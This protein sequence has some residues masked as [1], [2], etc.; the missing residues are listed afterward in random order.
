M[1]I[2]I[3]PFNATDIDFIESLIPRFSE[4]ELPHWRTKTEIDSINLKSLQEA[5]KTPDRNSAIFIAVDENENRAGFIHLQ[6]QADYFNAKKAAYISDIAV[7]SKFEGRGVGRILLDKAREW[8]N[9]QECSLISLYVFANNM[10]AR[11][12]Y[13][14]LGFKEEVVKYILSNEKTA[15]G[16]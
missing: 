9:E 16:L 10:R 7:D 14:K 3:R 6:L 8:A 13:E 5:M 15:E 11:K 12:I 4:F 2:Q 1:N